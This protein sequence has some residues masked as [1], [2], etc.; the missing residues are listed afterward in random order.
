MSARSL[1]NIIFCYQVIVLWYPQSEILE[2]GVAAFDFHNSD[3]V[4][5]DA[6]ML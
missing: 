1:G 4:Q 3:N 2:V 6:A 5:G